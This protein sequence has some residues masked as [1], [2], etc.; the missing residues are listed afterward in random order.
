MTTRRN[1][2]RF[3]IFTAALVASMGLAISTPASASG[4]HVQGGGGI[5]AVYAFGQLFVL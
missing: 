3:A 5:Y 4:I 1:A 2:S